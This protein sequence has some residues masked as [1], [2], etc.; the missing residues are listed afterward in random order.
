MTKIIKKIY[1]FRTEDEKR[2]NGLK[3]S[4]GIT[5]Q[6]GVIRFILKQAYDLELKKAGRLPP[7]A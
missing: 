1:D 4:L 2:L 6:I 7:M 5:S 3:K